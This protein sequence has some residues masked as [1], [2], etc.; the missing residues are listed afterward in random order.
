MDSA[1]GPTRRNLGW[2]AAPVAGG[3]MIVGVFRSMLIGGTAC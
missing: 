2:I 3:W 1:H